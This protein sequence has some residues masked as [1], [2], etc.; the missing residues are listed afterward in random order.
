MNLPKPAASVVEWLLR[1][2]ALREALAKRDTGGKPRRAAVDQARLLTEVARRVAE[3]AEELPRG[4]RPAVLLC[5]YRD[6]VTWA[7]R[8]ESG[9]TPD[10]RLAQLWEAASPERLK[11]AAGDEAARDVVRD[12][13]TTLPEGGSLGAPDTSVSLARSFTEALVHEIGAPDRE[14]DR[15]RAQRYTRVGGVVAAVAAL[16][17]SLPYLLRGPDLA[18]DRR[19]ELSSVYGGCDQRGKCG[20]LMFHTEVQANPWMTLDLGAIKT[21]RSVELTNRSDCCSERA[22]PLV[23]ELSTDK[24]KFSEVARR[25]ENFETWT[26][27]FKA[28]KARYVRLK[29]VKASTALHL[30][31]VVVR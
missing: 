26:A 27:K 1:T 25:D 23:I 20:E 9:E 15:I 29:S 24:R 31:D 13:L 4:S 16:V 30:E 2:S 6:A 12:L 21:V 17:L 3:P 18:G 5:L 7:L 14:V 8:A 11:V 10:L 28:R 19:F 22:V